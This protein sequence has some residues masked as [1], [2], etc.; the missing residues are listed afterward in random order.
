MLPTESTDRVDDFIHIL[1]GYA[2]HQLVKLVETRFDLLVVVWAVFIMA[3]IEHPQN[4]IR[5][6]AI[7]WVLFNVG[8]QSFNVFFHVYHLQGWW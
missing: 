5:I 2:V 6:P 3:L 4:G 1:Q 8:V 7:W